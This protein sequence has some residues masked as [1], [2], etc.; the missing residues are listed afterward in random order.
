[1]AW[2]RVEQTLTGHRKVWQAARLLNT[3]PLRLVGHLIALWTAALDYIPAN[4]SLDGFNAAWLKQRAQ[5]E[6]SATKFEAA[7]IEVGLIDDNPRL[8][9]DWQE[10]AGPLIEQR[11]YERNRKR[12][13]RDDRR[14]NGGTTAGQSPG[15]HRDSG[16]TEAGKSRR[17][18]KSREDLRGISLKP[19]EDADGDPLNRPQ[20]ETEFVVALGR[21]AAPVD[22]D[23]VVL[24]AFYWKHDV[25]VL[26]KKRQG[27]LGYCRSY[28][29]AHVLATIFEAGIK[30][31]PE[32]YVL[33][34]LATPPAIH[35][36]QA[37][38]AQRSQR[39]LT[40]LERMEAEA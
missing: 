24:E 33:K 10:Y 30:D 14:D 17:Q 9:H 6:G 36:E 34:M 23:Q 5:W 40:E 4:G 27:L 12:Q 28:G 13:R 37:D 2:I 18:S 39:A 7:L 11:E 19:E 1:M 15:Q 31:H 3:H 8:I 20:T 26:K 22:R 16:G 21:A 32:A 35:T 25:L 38:R 29:H